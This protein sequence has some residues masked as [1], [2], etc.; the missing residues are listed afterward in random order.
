[1]QIKKSI[2][3]ALIINFLYAL[4]DEAHQYFVP[5]RYPD[6]R[7][8]AADMIGALLVMVGILIINRLFFSEKSE[9]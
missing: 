2:W 6:W 3:I 1:M 4:S 5:G 7:D 8:V 9:T